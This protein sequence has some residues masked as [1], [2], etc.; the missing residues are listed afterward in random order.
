MKFYK[1]VLPMRFIKF[2]RY[3]SMCMIV[4]AVFL[5]IPAVEKNFNR[6]DC[7]FFTGVSNAVYETINAYHQMESN[8]LLTR[9]EAQ[10]NAIDKLKSLYGDSQEYFLW[11]L[12]EGESVLFINNSINENECQVSNSG[13]VRASF[14]EPWRWKVITALA[15]NGYDA[16][17]LKTKQEVLLFTSIVIL[18]IIVLLLLNIYHTYKIDRIRFDAEKFL[19]ES[20][21]RF[22]VIFDNIADGI[23]LINHGSRQFAMFNKTLLG[24][25]GYSRDELIA[26]KLTDLYPEYAVDMVMDDIDKIYKGESAISQNVPLKCKN[27]KILYVDITIVPILLNKQ[28]YLMGIFRDITYRRMREDKFRYRIEFD[29]LVCTMSTILMDAPSELI[30]SEI[31]NALK[32]IGG[33][34]SVERAFV[35]ILRP[36]TNIFDVAHEWCAN[37]LPSRVRAMSNLD[38][39]IHFSWFYRQIMQES[40]VYFP[41]I[42]NLPTSAFDLKEM[43]IREGVKS[44]IYIPLSSTS[45]VF[46]YL[47]FESFMEEKNWDDDIISLFSIVAE[48]ISNAIARKESALA[49]KKSEERYRFLVNNINLGIVLLDV[50]YTILMVNDMIC[51]LYKKTADEFIGKKCFTRFAN[52]DY[53]CSNCPCMQIVNNGTHKILESQ[54]INDTGDRYDVRIK[55]YPVFNDEHKISGFIEVIEDITETKKAEEEMKK[56]IS[57]SDHA[58]YGLGILNIDGTIEYINKYFAE[59]HGYTVEEVKG[60][61][62][63]IFHSKEQLNQVDEVKNL[64]L[65][66]GSFQSMEILHIRKDGSVFP[67]LTNA[68]LIRDE[69]DNPKFIEITCIDITEHKRLEEELMK[70]RKL[71][72]IGILAGG[73]AHDFNNMLTAILGN[74]SLAMLDLRPEHDSLMSVLKNAEKAS[75]QARELSQQL[76]TFS[77][78]GAPIRKTTSIEGLIRDSANFS[79]KG[80]NV[81]CEFKFD[82]KLFA[83]D[84]DKGQI[85]Q[86]VNN[87]VINAKQAMKTGGTITIS[88]ENMI[89]KR[90]CSID[91]KAGKYI[92]ISIADQGVGI[93]R[94]NLAK[95]YDPYFTTKPKGSGLG[96]ATSYSIIKKHEG[97]IEV[98]S[99]ENI[100]TTFHI[101]LPASKKTSE[102]NQKYVSV[103]K[104]ENRVFTG[105]GTVLV[106]D[107]EELIRNIV[108]QLLV[109]LG[110]QVEFAADGTEAIDIYRSALEEGRKFDAVIMDLT[111]P[112]GMGGKETMEKLL[113]IDPDIKAIVS[114]GYSNDPVMSRYKDYGFSGI[115]RKPFDIKE[116]SEVLYGLVS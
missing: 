8:G 3:L 5:L 84:I 9:N 68:V 56:F 94:E 75:L 37:G 49:F 61:H 45:R 21:R 95:I 11:V 66:Q 99:T 96:L 25:L 47:G 16:N 23:L 86:V 63:N 102:P 20:E 116:I 24:M 26:M 81:K 103:D 51:S 83:V 10:Q 85:S 105:K 36:L 93:S 98:D 88:C 92:H 101:Y 2:I 50:N 28:G 6:P 1:I 46:G 27:G 48:I 90:D 64:L 30:D 82:K 69:Q 53:V 38:A 100:G 58:A 7:E 111:I 33:F 19:Y 17:I 35:C 78:G 55:M 72:S 39:S 114:S 59:I 29:K 110:Y 42:K 79:L 40:V 70:T 104:D 80:S 15:N 115:A 74:I 87:M 77:R 13:N 112:G 18:V 106:M 65:E 34:L 73:I 31:D 14:F 4:S 32:A 52:I 107:D 22:E 108:G 54:L 91:L 62:V 12:R 89:V 67:M 44:F 57:V 71:E 76:L 97:I 60:K 109:H 113:V 43:C 41:Q